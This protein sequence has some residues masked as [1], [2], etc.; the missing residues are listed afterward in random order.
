MIETTN[1][2]HDTSDA[3]E[4]L[5][6]PLK[7]SEISLLPKSVITSRNGDVY[8]IVFPYKDARVDMNRLDEVFG[9]RWNMYTEVTPAGEGAVV[10]V[11]VSVFD[12]EEF[13][14]VERSA[15]SFA[16]QLTQDALKGA[17]SDALKRVGFAFGI[18]RELYEMGPFYVRLEN[19]EYRM[20][21][22]VPKMNGGMAGWKME[23]DGGRVKILD[24]KGAV[25]YEGRIG[26]QRTA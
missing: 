15:V 9:L 8:A 23:L 16:E 1:V 5:K 13:T 12:D 6:K 3:M 25:R 21:G 22:N 10:K 26:S 19:G 2:T 18:G 24:K 17:E 7:A 20:Q 11:R 4:K 14:S